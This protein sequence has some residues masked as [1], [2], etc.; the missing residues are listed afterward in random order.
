MSKNNS[1]KGFSMRRCILAVAVMSGFFSTSSY[2]IDVDAGDYEAAPAG[3]N[4]GLLYL[5]HANRNS[6]YGNGNKVTGSNGLKTDIGILRAVHFMDIGGTIV[7]PQILVPFGRVAGTDDLAGPL[8]S[9]NGIGDPILAATIWVQNNQTDRVFTGITPYVIVPVGS[10]NNN[11]ALNIGE[12]RWKFDIQAAHVRRL[13]E[14]FSVDLVGDV[15]WFGRN[16]DFGAAS[17][18]LDQK[19]LAQ[20]QGWLRYH[21][22]PTADLRLLASHT[23]GGETKINGAAQ[24]D[25]ISTTKFG[26]GGSFFI[27]PKTQII[28]MYGQD[29]NVENGF[30]ESARFNVRIL[31]LF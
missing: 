14:K 12:N 17:A 21:L 22:S 15:M 4:V 18:N 25:R 20:F 2:A 27:G 28:G 10:Y 26:V 31:Q 24:N 23:T 30:K 6:L 29:T 3:T 7:D 8:G 11:N 13:S 5:Q 9:A 16:N 19:P 1:I